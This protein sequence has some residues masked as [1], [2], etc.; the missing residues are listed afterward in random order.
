[1][2]PYILGAIFARGGSKGLPGKNIRN[3]A[4]KPLLAYAIETGLAIS[5]IDKI[6]VSTDDEEIAEVAKKYGAEVPFI[7][8]QH[9]AS[10]SSPEIFSWQ[11]AIRAIEEQ[12]GQKVDILV[13]IPTT[14]PLRAV[15]DVNRCLDKLLQSDADVVVI[16]KEA[17]RNPYFNMVIVDKNDNL[18][19]VMPRKKHISQR[20]QAPEVYDMTTVAYAAKASYVLNTLSILEGKVKAVKVPRER[21][22]DID[23]MLDFE[24]AE[25]L[26]QKRSRNNEIIV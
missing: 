15:E 3:L 12:T 26:M 25:F 1:M 20:Q 4:G 16:V 11:H 9:L 22:L 13:S 14:S 24:I 23:T 7:R 17:E 8:P 10:D 5:A 19:L 6:I 2:K 21:A 18:E